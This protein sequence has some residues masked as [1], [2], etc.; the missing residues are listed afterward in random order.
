[1]ELLWLLVQELLGVVNT[2]L[3]LLSVQVKQMIVRAS[4]PAENLTFVTEALFKQQVT[5]LCTLGDA[6]WALAE[7]RWCN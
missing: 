1:V 3:R 5:L 4:V 7:A 2:V 6:G